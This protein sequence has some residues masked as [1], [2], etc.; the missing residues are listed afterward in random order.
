MLMEMCFHL[1]FIE[2]LRS[3]GEKQYLDHDTGKFQAETKL[4]KDQFKR[5]KQV[6]MRNSTSSAFKT[7]LKWGLEYTSTIMS[8]TG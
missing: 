2:K 4:P 5:A 7:I 8:K 1:C 3:A 6:E